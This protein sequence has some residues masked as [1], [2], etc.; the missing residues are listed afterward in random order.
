MVTLAKRAASLWISVAAL[1]AGLIAF[2]SSAAAAP[3]TVPGC[4]PKPSS[5]SDSCVRGTVRASDGAI[6]SSLEPARVGI[7]TRSVF[8]PTGDETSSVTLRFDQNIALNLAGIPTC[9]ASELSGKSVA[10][11]YEQCGPGADGS[12]PSEGNAYLSA[13]GNV[14]GIA[15]TVPSAN[16]TACTMIFKGADD[17]HVTLY[18]RA[19]V[20]PVTGCNNPAT[21]TAGSV[22]VIFTGTL[23]HMPVSSPYDVVLTVANVDAATPA[24][25]DFYA[26]L[27]RGN[28]FRA[29]CPN[30][31]Y[32]HR[33]VG[34]FDYTSTP[35]DVIAPPYPG[36]I[37]E[38]SACGG[39]GGP[40]P[41]PPDSTPNTKITKAKVKQRRRKAKF[42][43]KATRGPAA[44]FECKLKRKGHGAKGFRRC[45]SPKTYRH[46]KRGQYR[47][48]VRAVGPGGTDNSPATDKFKI[49]RHRR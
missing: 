3:P 2:P 12:P 15:S 10:Q 47:F 40:P 6:G 25:D 24:L 11:A 42:K 44:S 34:V 36:T 33:L 37:L 48:S 27:S 8:N 18:S 26:T 5:N 43:F 32:K 21:N 20:T 41:P 4:V 13:P 7:R 29:R 17:N 30:P 49:K 46:L 45:S 14:S 9:P 22:S 16:L 19:P 38:E 23:S 31:T 39:D 1:G 35:T 28:A